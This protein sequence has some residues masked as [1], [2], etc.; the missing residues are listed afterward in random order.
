[1]N[2]SAKQLQRLKIRKGAK[3]FT[4]GDKHNASLA[5]LQKRQR[6]RRLQLVGVKGG[7]PLSVSGDLTN[8]VRK[9]ICHCDTSQLLHWQVMV[10]ED[11]FF[12]ILDS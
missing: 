11:I 10:F 4:T 6:D 3:P 2:R 7:D 8:F 5:E 1:M 12:L 9:I